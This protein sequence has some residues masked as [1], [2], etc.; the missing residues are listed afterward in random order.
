MGR[1]DA[2]AGEDMTACLSCPHEENRP[3]WLIQPIPPG[4]GWWSGRFETAALRRQAGPRDRQEALRIPAQEGLFGQEPTQCRLRS[5][6]APSMTWKRWTCRCATAATS[7]LES[8]ARVGLRE[9][10][11]DA[12][13]LPDG[14][15]IF[16]DPSDPKVKAKPGEELTY[17]VE[18]FETARPA[19][20]RWNTGCRPRRV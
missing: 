3:Q 2:G 13:S 10:T 17:S 18:V 11:G 4:D 5:A 8:A 15:L 12:I 7:A 9:L 19:E 1:R 20:H 14:G 6:G 16:D